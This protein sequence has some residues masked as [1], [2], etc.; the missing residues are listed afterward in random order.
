MVQGKQM[1]SQCQ[2]YFLSSFSHGKND[3]SIRIDE[4]TLNRSSTV[5]YLGVIIGYKLNWCEHIAHVTNNI[6]NAIGILYI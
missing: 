4:S 3:L 5:K 6:S 1:I 2:K